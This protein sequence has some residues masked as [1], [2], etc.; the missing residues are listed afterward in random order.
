[1]N[2]YIPA[3]HRNLGAGY[4]AKKDY[5]KA[6]ESHEKAIELEPNN[7]VNYHNLG[8]AFFRLNNF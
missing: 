8:S 3:Y 5:H 1:M 7:G 2:P 6:I 4:Y